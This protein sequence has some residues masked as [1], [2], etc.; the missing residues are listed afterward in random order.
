MNPDP[1]TEAAGLVADGAILDWGSISSRLSNDGEREIAGELTLIAR[2]A[3]EHRRLHQLLPSAEPTPTEGSSLDRTSWG[4]LELL[5]VLGRG[6]YGTVYRAWDGR[7]DRQVALKLFHGARDPEAVMREGRMLAK[8][9][10][11]HVVCV[12]GADVVEGVAGIW[13]ELVR[14]RNLEQIVK[15]Q[16]P[17]SAQEA[18]LVGL[19]MSR[20]LAAV[21]GVGLLHC[22]IKAQNVIREP[23]GRL[24]LMDLGAGRTVPGTGDTTSSGMTG[25]PR[26]MAPEVFNRR[27]ASPQSD[28]Y[29]LGVLLFYLVT[30]RFPVDGKS[31]AEIK[32]AHDSGRQLHLRDVRPDL[33]TGYL[34]E[35]SR[36]IAADPLQRHHSAGQLEAALLS[37]AAPGSQGAPAD[38]PARRARRG[39]AVTATVATV[40]LAAALIWSI[41]PRS[42]TPLGGSVRSIAVTPIRNLTGDPAR[43][44]LADGLTEVL[45]SNMARIKAFSVPSF[46]AVAGYRDRET[47]PAV[48]A[49]ALDV[50]L[51]L[52]GSLLEADG[53]LQLE[54]HLTDPNGRVLWAQELTRPA[55]GMLAAQGEIARL[56]ARHLAVDLSSD[57][58]ST[59]T[60]GPVDPRAQ[61]AYLRGLAA[62][63]TLAESGAREAIKYFR[64]STELAPAFAPA[65][66]EWSMAE[67]RLVQFANVSERSQ[68]VQRAKDLAAKALQLDSGQPTGFVAQATAQFYYDWD[69][70][71]AERSFRG[72]IAAAPSNAAGSHGLAWLLAARGRVD[73]A[74][75]IG[76]D[77]VRLDPLAASRLNMLATLHYYK[78]DYPRAIELMERTLK[79]AP[80]HPTAH[81]GLGRIHAAMGHYELAAEQITLALKRSRDMNWLPELAC[82]L[83]HAGQ[84]AKVDAI[85]K[86]LAER[87]QHGEAYSLDHGAHIAAARGRIDEGFTILRQAL[88]RR[89]IDMLWMGVDPRLDG[90]RSDPRFEHL[91]RD[92]HL[93]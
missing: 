84:D 21:H 5:D 10:H 61:E 12:Y 19:E 90:Y 8:I 62:Q 70:D 18:T 35:V 1:L 58:R 60:Q 56:V 9:R 20:A 49:D 71:A 37:L 93:R 86:E 3:D 39:V 54:M 45:I 24:V 4:H 17:M 38:N 81:F 69:F 66:A 68:G 31:L 63:A 59:L 52:A 91:M 7:L 33:P 43:N 80:G 53:R 85:L 78:R 92:A 32:T 64:E 76:A 15:E 29:S 82:V 55:A 23:G 77:A 14:G 87:E 2:I 25:T 89:E 28:L 88:D 42:R 41:A 75:Q 67:L 30:G 11:D 83:A 13:M 46:G 47:A 44:Y 36:A 79:V 34:R 22:D 57:E 50:D 48:I 6:S 73:E 72:A 26:Y 16:G 27:P 65:W 74:L 40:A 51:L